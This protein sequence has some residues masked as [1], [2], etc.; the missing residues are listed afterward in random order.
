ML[1][2]NKY[3]KGN[4]ILEV[5]IALAIVSFCLTLMVI[6]FLNIQKSSLP[7]IKLKANEAAEYY[8][9]ETIKNKTFLNENFKKEEFFVNKTAE[10]HST[11]SDCINI[12]VIVFDNNHKKI[13]ELQSIIFNAN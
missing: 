12:R 4:S 10:S 8:L 1:S 11:Y 6:I 2:K 5:L 7:F 13:T 3:L 9:N